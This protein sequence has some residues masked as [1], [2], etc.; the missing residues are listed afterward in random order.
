MRTGHSPFDGVLRLSRARVRGLKVAAAAIVLLASAG[1]GYAEDGAYRL[2]PED[3]IRLKVFEWRPS[4]DEVFEW[5]ALND[6]FIVSAARSLSI[7]LIGEVPVKGSPPQDVARDIAE[8]LRKRMGLTTPPDTAI[9]IVQYRPFF[10]A[11]DVVH[12]GPYPFHPGL[13]VLEAVAIAGGLPEPRDVSLT[14][15]SRDVISGEGDLAQWARDY[16]A[17]LA[18]RARLQAEVNEAPGIEMPA[19]FAP[20][21]SSAAV[22]QVMK[23]ET[24]IFESRRRAFETQ[25]DALKELK[26]FLQKEAVSLDAQLTTIDTQMTLVNKELTGVSSL[27]EKGM[28]VA[29]R[30]M[31]LQRSVAQIQGDRLSME[32]NKLRVLEEISKTDIAMIELR[33]TRTTDDS[34]E[35]RDTQLKL[36]EIV[37]KSDTGGKL[38]YE[39]KVTAPRLMAD[40]S[41]QSLR[42]PSYALVRRT[43]HGP[44][45]VDAAESTEMGPGDTVKVTL[46]P[47][48]DLPGELD[49]TA[50]SSGATGAVR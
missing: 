3:K 17:A 31:A 33:N 16:D 35:L 24:L 43:E 50:M 27:V 21:A 28:V 15:L 26:S 37:G 2:G 10:V 8:R 45:T 44:E 36:E 14:R 19:A 46:P 42:E 1:C 6:D 5:K 13:T 49:A 18:R 12:P 20:R 48:A 34:V 7:P 9:D 38:L 32:T 47:P 25:F 4:Q 22:V 30:Q 41:R 39:A 29:P 40:R 11:G 23:A